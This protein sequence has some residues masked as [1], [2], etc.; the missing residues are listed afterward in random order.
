[1]NCLPAGG[2]AMD[3]NYIMVEILIC[4]ETTFFIKNK[5]LDDI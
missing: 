4:V 5:P 1:M 3:N 2:S